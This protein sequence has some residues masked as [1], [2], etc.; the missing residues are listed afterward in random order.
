MDCSAAASGAAPK[1]TN[2]RFPENTV[3]PA[4]LDASVASDM[5]G[6]A[7]SLQAE[8]F[9]RKIFCRLPL[10]VSAYMSVLDV[11]NNISGHGSPATGNVGVIVHEVPLKM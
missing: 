8:P 4:T 7:S 9:Q 6:V 1:A 10:A 3:S 2:P 11:P 5:S